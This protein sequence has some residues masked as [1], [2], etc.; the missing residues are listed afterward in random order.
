LNRCT[1]LLFY[2]RGFHSVLSP[3]APYLLASLLLYGIN[4]QY[5]CHIFN[6]IRPLI[7]DIHSVWPCGQENLSD[8]FMPSSHYGSTQ[9]PSRTTKHRTDKTREDQG[10][11]L[12]TGA[13]R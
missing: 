13:Y 9:L 3:F 12:T 1:I 7:S 2:S 4:K 6:S 10:S 11:C 5:L 8:L